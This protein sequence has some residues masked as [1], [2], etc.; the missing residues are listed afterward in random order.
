MFDDDSSIRISPNRIS[1]GISN[2]KEE[3][4]FIVDDDFQEDFWIDE[5]SQQLLEESI[6]FQNQLTTS[7]TFEKYTTTGGSGGSHTSKASNTSKA[8]KASDIHFAHDA[9]KVS[10][11]TVEMESKSRNDIPID[12]RDDYQYGCVVCY[13]TSFKH[14]PCDEDDEIAYCASCLENSFPDSFT[15]EMRDMLFIPDNIWTNQSCQV[16][17]S[18]MSPFIFCF[19]ACKKHISEI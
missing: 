6:Y 14:T 19:P 9:S 15:N 10:E 11:V 16:C 7:N 4:D 1:N 17:A 2:G 18:E 13:Y 3:V 5:D 8:S 12:C